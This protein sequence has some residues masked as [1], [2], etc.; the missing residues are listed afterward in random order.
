[1]N[2]DGRVALVTGGGGARGIGEAVCIKLA[3]RGALVAVSDVDF[4]SAQSVAE[5]LSARGL[6]AKAFQ[7]NVADSKDAQRV[8]S[9]VEAQLGDIDILVNNAGVSRA[10]NFLELEEAEWNRVLNINL[11]GVFLTCKA[12]LPGM[13][14]RGK[15]RV[16]NMSSILGK[17]GLPRLAA[18]SASKFAILGLTQTL[19]AEMARHGITVN[20]VCPG[21]VETP[22]HEGLVNDLLAAP[23][24]PGSR[25]DIDAWMKSQI[26]LGHPQTAED[27]AEMVAFLASD[28][29]RNITAASFH[30][31]GGL[32]PR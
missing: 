14:A 21:T 20:A 29:A 12:V 6:C 22:L 5:G 25:K 4:A 31:D 9:E 30:V 8:V 7:H 24:G 10:V 15:G 11:G 17:Q 28:G 1:M 26:P 27:I 19:A 18:Y 3:E 16:I 13:V 32:M 23:G 2:L